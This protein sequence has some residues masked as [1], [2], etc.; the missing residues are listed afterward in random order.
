MS[1]DIEY[2]KSIA[3][4][5]Y[6]KFKREDVDNWVQTGNAKDLV[7]SCEPHPTPQA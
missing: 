7:A 2:R 4:E 6:S 5:L 3:H 1:K